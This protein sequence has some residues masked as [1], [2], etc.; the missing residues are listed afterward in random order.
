MFPKNST[1]FGSANMSQLCASS[2]P[3]S[4]NVCLLQFDTFSE[5]NSQIGSTRVLHVVLRVHVN[6]SPS[7]FWHIFSYAPRSWRCFGSAEPS[8]SLQPLLRYHPEVAMKSGLV[9]RLQPAKCDI[10]WTALSVHWWRSNRVIWTCFQV[11]KNSYLRF[12]DALLKKETAWWSQM[13]APPPPLFSP[14]S[15]HVAE[16]R[17]SSGSW[18]I[19]SFPAF[20]ENLQLNRCPGYGYIHVRKLQFV[21]CIYYIKY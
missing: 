12:L 8:R 2:H 16:V 18:L 11:R 9:A 4:P 6:S 15:F 21:L 1:R 19:I 20:K 13:E 14:S 7:S 17:S 10:A 5:L 3:D